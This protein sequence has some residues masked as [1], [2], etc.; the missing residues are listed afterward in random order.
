MTYGN[1][2]LFPKFISIYQLES[3]QT[4]NLVTHLQCLLIKKLEGKAWRGQESK[5]SSVEAA[6]CFLFCRVLSNLS[7]LLTRYEAQ[8]LL[9]SHCLHRMLILYNRV[10][11]T[12]LKS[13]QIHKNQFIVCELSSLSVFQECPS[14]RLF[15]P[16]HSAKCVLIT[17][18]PR[19]SL[20]VCLFGATTQ[21]CWIVSMLRR[22]RGIQPF[23]Q[24][25]VLIAI[26]LENKFL[27]QH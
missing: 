5:V 4:Q 3:P 7:H 11:V 19:K 1:E 14:G 18:L 6:R 21:T 13:S 15:L 25:D 12:Q 27:T 10:T 2:S 17:S 23:S 22:Q 9:L 24:E 16:V 8:G 26:G 20:S